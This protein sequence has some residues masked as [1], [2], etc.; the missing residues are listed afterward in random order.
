MLKTGN[1]F[2]LAEQQLQKEK[3]HYKMSDVIDYAVKIRKWLDKHSGSKY[4]VTKAVYGKKAQR[5]AI[6]R[7]TGK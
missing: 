7:E 2:E 4:G 3:K 1:L 6:Y 5:K